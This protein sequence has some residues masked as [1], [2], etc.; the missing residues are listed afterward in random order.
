M[1]DFL[2]ILPSEGVLRVSPSPYSDWGDVA[3]KLQEEAFRAEYVSCFW[4]W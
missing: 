3:V 4:A 1:R 2:L